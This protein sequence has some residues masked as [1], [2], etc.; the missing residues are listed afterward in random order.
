VVVVG[1]GVDD[2]LRLGHGYKEERGVLCLTATPLEI[3]TKVAPPEPASPVFV[4]AH[5]LS[6][7]ISSPFPVRSPPEPRLACTACLVHS[8]TALPLPAFPRS[9][10]SRLSR[11]PWIPISCPALS[12]PH[13]STSISRSQ[14]QSHPWPPVTPVHASPANRTVPQPG[15]LPSHVGN[16][17]P[18]RSQISSQSSSLASLLPVTPP[19]SSTSSQR[20]CPRQFPPS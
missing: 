10:L 4:F 5:N 8:S 3:W 6:V 2:R 18:S 16:G 17:H 15:S 14:G 7:G 11:Y 19:S 12:P 1:W 13:P 9:P 20:P